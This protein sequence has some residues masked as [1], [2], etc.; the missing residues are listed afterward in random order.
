MRARG[1]L[2]LL[3]WLFLGF[4]IPLSSQA[5]LPGEIQL[6]QSDD[7][8]DWEKAV[9]LIL[10][11]DQKTVPP[12]LVNAVTRRLPDLPPEAQLR[13]IRGLRHA[14]AQDSRVQAAFAHLAGGNADPRVGQEALRALDRLR[15]SKES[16]Q[17][18]H[19]PA[20]PPGWQQP[21]LAGL[22]LLLVL[23]PLFLGLALSLWCFRLLQLH[24]LLRDLPLSRIRLLTP[25]LVLLRGEVQLHGEPLFH[26]QTGERCIYSLAPGMRGFASAWWTTAAG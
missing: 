26:P 20:S 19:S 15:N 5:F 12:V 9:T 7:P 4:G 17:P 22:A 13:L 25:G 1:L 16:P 24:R 8:A 18:T 3:A 11:D 14:L 23:A 10:P 2:L 21:L 6:L